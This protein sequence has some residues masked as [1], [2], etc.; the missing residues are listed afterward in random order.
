PVRYAWG[1]LECLWSVGYAS[2]NPVIGDATDVELAAQYPGEPGTLFEALFACRFI[3]LT[4]DGCYQIH[5]L[6]DNAPD[7]VKARIRMRKR[8]ANLQSR[9]KGVPNRS[10]QSRTSDQTRPDQTR[11]DQ[12]GA[13]APPSPAGPAT[14]RKRPPRTIPDPEADMDHAPSAVPRPDLDPA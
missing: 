8:R 5:D 6:I 12:G 10:E 1:L 11:P 9:K 14:K 3:E 2:G 4:T 7:Y 13:G